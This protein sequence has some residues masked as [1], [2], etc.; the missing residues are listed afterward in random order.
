M[1]VSAFLEDL[2]LEDLEDLDG[3][4][5]GRGVAGAAVGITGAEE[6]VVVTGAAEEGDDVVGEK[7]W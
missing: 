6:G 2:D 5:D 3:A 4:F 1:V 7:Y